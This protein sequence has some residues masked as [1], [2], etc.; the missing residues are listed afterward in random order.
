M[1]PVPWTYINSWRCT[2]CGICCKRFEVVLK[3]NEWLRLIQTYGASVTSADINKFYLGKRAD[4]SCVFLTSSNSVCFCGLQNM[5]PVACKLWPFKILDKPRYGGESE[6]AFDYQGRRLYVYIDPF[7]PEILYG[8]PSAAMVYK[9]I[10]EFV[11]IA[12]GLREKQFYTTATPLYDLYP[13]TRRDY[14]LI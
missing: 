5:K 8:K 6:A 14:R 4:G 9:V 2:G 10:P 3:F 11:E 13:K 12:L 1:M 7:C